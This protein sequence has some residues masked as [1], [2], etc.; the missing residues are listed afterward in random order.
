MISDLT[1]EGRSF[2]LIQ[3]KNSMGT[4]S[5]GMEEKKHRRQYSLKEQAQHYYI[6]VYEWGDNEEH[7]VCTPIYSEHFGGLGRQWE[8]KE[9][10][11][12]NEGFIIHRDVI[13]GI[14][15]ERQILLVG[16]IYE[17]FY[18]PKYTGDYDGQVDAYYYTP[19]CSI[20]A[21]IVWC[22]EYN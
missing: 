5:L 2:P 18:Y 3:Y 1:I 17:N 12:R 9:L 11:F 19:L 21:D 22:E 4:Y 8:S 15:I 13:V 20:Q 6:D 14:K 16:Q 10:I 7:N